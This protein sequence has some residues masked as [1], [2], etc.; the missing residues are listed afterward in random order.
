MDN[1]EERIKELEKRVKDLEA[2]LKVVMSKP[3]LDLNT[4]S[5][6]QQV[7]ETPIL[8]YEKKAVDERPGQINCRD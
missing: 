4:N 8:F 7:V 3:I 2:A 1:Q 6:P 5:L